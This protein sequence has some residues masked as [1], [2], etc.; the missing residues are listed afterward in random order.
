MK[1]KHLFLACSFVTSGLYAQTVELPVDYVR[2]QHHSQEANS[3]N[4]Q[5][6]KYLNE[7][8]QPGIVFFEDKELAALLRYNALA[9]EF[10][11]K[12]ITDGEVSSIIR[13]KDIHFK[14]GST[15]FGIYNFLDKNNGVTEGYFEILNEGS[16]Q[17][18]KRN[19]VTY[20]E[21]EPAANSYS[22]GKP[23]RYITASEYY[24]LKENLPAEKINFRKKEIL[25]ILKS[26]DADLHVKENKL[27]LN[28]EQEIIKLLVFLNAQN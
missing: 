13:S 25:K 17:L 3:G 24:L 6:S 11:I 22:Q 23:A 19:I 15:N 16:L 7:N 27:K 2:N 18:L 12:N 14:V 26:D 1:F 20:N 10:E 21:A 5:G 4:V 8:F 28:N 9:G